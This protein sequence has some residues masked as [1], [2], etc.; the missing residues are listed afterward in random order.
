MSRGGLYYLLHRQALRVEAHVRSDC[1]G[2]VKQRK[3]EP[4]EWFELK[5]KSRKDTQLLFV[6]THSASYHERRSNCFVAM[7]KAG[8]GGCSSANDTYRQTP[9]E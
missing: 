7:S 9:R 5:L 3:G 4:S 1:E 6:S 2:V 8:D